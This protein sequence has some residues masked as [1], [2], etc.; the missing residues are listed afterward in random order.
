MTQK[1]NKEYSFSTD[2]DLGDVEKMAMAAS[3]NMTFAMSG[4]KNTPENKKDWESIV[5]E[6]EQMEKDGIGVEIP[7]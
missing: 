2:K 3:R 1:T 4:A 6:F 7:F 5:E